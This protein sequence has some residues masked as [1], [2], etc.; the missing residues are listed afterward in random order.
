[1]KKDYAKP[2]FEFITFNS[3]NIMNLSATTASPLTLES[4][5]IVNYEDI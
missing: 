5:E 3:E 1:M 4:L 2:I